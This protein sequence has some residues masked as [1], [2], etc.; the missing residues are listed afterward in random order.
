MAATVAPSDIVNLEAD[1]W[2]LGVLKEFR[3]KESTKPEWGNQLEVV[4]AVNGEEKDPLTDWVALR[5]GMGSS[6]PA[7]LRQLLNGLVDK[8]KETAIT[9]FMD[10]EGEPSL[11]YEWSYEE[12]SLIDNQLS[13]W[14]PEAKL[15]KGMRILFM[16]D[17]KEQEG[18]KLYKISKYKSAVEPKKKTAKPTVVED[19]DEKVPF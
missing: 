11:P 15:E 17:F 6:G 2:Y 18:R 7:K 10:P 8:P 14:Q 3:I 13:H 9:G 4:W 16:G 5:L 19:D 12:F 1:T